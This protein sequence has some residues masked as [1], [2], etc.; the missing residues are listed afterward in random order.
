MT[1]RVVVGTSGAIVLMVAP[2]ATVPAP[3]HKFVISS[4]RVLR[5]T[6]SPMSRR[7][8]DL[9]ERQGV[10]TNFIHNFDPSQSAFGTF[11]FLERAWLAALSRLP[12]RH[13]PEGP[14]LPLLECCSKIQ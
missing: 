2:A 1:V 10:A 6:P 4:R 14:A 12:E 13:H 5:P 3:Q 9:W 11:G 8:R 7:S